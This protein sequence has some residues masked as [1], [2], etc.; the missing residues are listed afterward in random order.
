MAARPW[1]GP[2]TV[3]HTAPVRGSARRRAL[4]SLPATRPLRPSRAG[5]TV[6]APGRRYVIA[7]L[8][9]RAPS[10][11]RTRGRCSASGCRR[12]PRHDA[13]RSPGSRRSGSAR[14]ERGRRRDG[15]PAHITRRAPDV[16]SDAGET[17]EL[18]ARLPDE[19][20]R[21]HEHVPRRYAAHGLVERDDRRLVK[22]PGRVIRA[23]GGVVSGTVMTSSP[24]ES[25][26]FTSTHPRIPGTLPQS[27]CCQIDHPWPPHS[28]AGSDGRRTPQCATH[29]VSKP[30]FTTA[31]VSPVRSAQGSSA[32][33]GRTPMRSR[34]RRSHWRIPPR[35]PP[36][37]QPAGRLEVEHGDDVPRLQAR[38]VEEMVRF[39]DG[40]KGP[41]S[42]RAK[43]YAPNASWLASA[44]DLFRR[45]LWSMYVRP[46]VAPG[47]H[48]VMARARHALPSIRPWWWDTSMPRI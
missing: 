35:Q 27:L 36:V 12:G 20:A 8:P 44:C 22:S 11:R 32:T 6:H 10:A 28:R 37:R 41:L 14:R 21:P 7:A 31:V 29:S 23:V 1:F 5:S 42:G 43:W 3:V 40:V 26:R 2:V 16:G 47:D 17:G 15:D 48:E 25:V 4:R 9:V 18:D 34:T 30:A 45:Y 13:P 38:D 46:S 24:S 39:A 19:P 33:I